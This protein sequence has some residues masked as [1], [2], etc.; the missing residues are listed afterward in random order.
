MAITMTD[1]AEQ[2]IL[3]IMKSSSSTVVFGVSGILLPELLYY[4]ITIYYTT[5]TTI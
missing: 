5:T 1:F 4:S 2:K 3:E